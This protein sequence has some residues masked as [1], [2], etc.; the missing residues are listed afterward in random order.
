VLGTSTRTNPVPA[1][2]CSVTRPTYRW[3][4]ITSTI[5]H[6]SNFSASLLMV[7]FQ[8][9]E[10]RT[11][12]L[13]KA[14][15]LL[16]QWPRLLAVSHRV[17]HPSTMLGWHVIPQTL[18]EPRPRLH[19]HVVASRTVLQRLDRVPQDHVDRVLVES[20]AP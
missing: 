4:P 10:N 17:F 18:G 6:C 11:S 1:I 2:T 12:K 8:A 7:S 20:V 3:W 9:I 19:V 14:L 13:P 5:A 15:G 16:G